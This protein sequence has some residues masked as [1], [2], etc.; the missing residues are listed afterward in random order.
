MKRWWSQ[1]TVLILLNVLCWPGVM[2]AQSAPDEASCN[3]FLNPKRTVR[4]KSVGPESCLML[5]AGATY[6]GLSLQRVDMGI[7]GTVDGYL[8]KTGNRIN[9]FT[10]APD[11]LF[12]QAGNPGPIYPGIGRYD[13]N[14]GSSMTVIY[15][16]D[17]SDWNGKLYVTAHGGGASFK[18]GS[19]RV[20]NKYLDRADQM[21][22]ISGFERLMLEKGYALAKTRRSSYNPGGD[23]VV[24]LEDG[25]RYREKNTTDNPRLILDFALIAEKV[26]QRR[27]GQEPTQTYL[28]GHSAGGRI[29]RE[30]NYVPGL[31]RGPD[32]GPVIDGILS[33]DSGAGL[34]LPIV[35]K[36]GKDVLFATEAERRAFVPQ[37]E[38]S[39]Q[40]YNRESI[41]EFPD[42]IS[43][44]YLMN[45][46]QNAK[47][48]R[49][50][51]LS[52]RHRVYEIRSISHATGE[53]QDWMM[54]P[55]NLNLVL[56]YDNFIDILD[57]WVVNGTPPPPS[58]SD[59][60][61]LGDRDGDGVIE[62]AAISFPEV[63]CPLG[64]FH[65]NNVGSG[66]STR[67]AFFTGDQ[68]L[69]PLSDNGVF[70]DMNRNGVWDVRE[71]PTQA[72]RRL[73]LLKQHE[74]LTLEKY[75]VCVYDSAQKLRREGLFSQRI[76][77]WYTENVKKVNLNPEPTERSAGGF[78]TE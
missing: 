32:G 59:W 54:N 43:G 27:L 47:I 16:V 42:Q 35:M 10:S 49:D 31:N 17:R 73:G 21:A 58:R 22:G 9:Y 51:G 66:G 37:L 38:V 3:D 53:N 56:L 60:A 19:L 44:N 76:A 52:D 30:T 2:A 14:K 8:A 78:A 6:Q 48:L 20:W 77:R 62:N 40:L 75:G 1:G 28:Y 41:G 63:V 15:P 65:Q 70:V 4:G 39:H 13:M 68:E 69:E 26:L 29:G 24:T 50:K 46:R 64:V 7:S 25:T 45:K 61:E 72:W 36:D 23:L 11:L 67:L 12:P 34:W 33:D 55:D 57:A 71:N 5:E 74:V 18:N